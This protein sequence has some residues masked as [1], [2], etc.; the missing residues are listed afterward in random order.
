VTRVFRIVEKAFEQLLWSSR[1]VVLVAV[2]ASLA[3]SMIMFYVASVDAYQLVGQALEYHV[4]AAHDA[5]ARLELRTMIV[6]HVV[7]IVDGYL[8]AAIMLIFG[9]GLYEL[10]ISRIDVAEKSD[11]ASRVLLIRSLDDL[12]DRLAKVVLLILV[13]KFFEYALHLQ[14]HK[15]HEL[16]YLAGGIVL[17]A[18][19][20]YLSH[21]KPPHGHK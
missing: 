17:V 20:L 7:E 21:A 9:L 5:A 19:A 16:L 18:A 12:K 15:A 6:A 13:V 4:Q 8:L 14:V 1:L 10:F 2:L 3:V 11:L